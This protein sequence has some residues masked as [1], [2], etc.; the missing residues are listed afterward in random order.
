[1]GWFFS[2]KYT[3]N[4]IYDPYADPEN[5]RLCV[6]CNEEI[7]FGH[8]KCLMCGSQSFYDVQ[9]GKT[10]KKNPRRKKIRRRPSVNFLMGLIRKVWLEEYRVP[11]KVLEKY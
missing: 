7:P 1:M 8:F 6:G 5:K 4:E 9:R 3:E 2:K 11:R 10:E